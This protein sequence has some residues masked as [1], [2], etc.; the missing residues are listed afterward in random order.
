MK[1]LG[2]GFVIG[3]LVV[4]FWQADLRRG[5]QATVAQQRAELQLLRGELALGHELARVALHLGRTAHL[6]GLLC[7]KVYQDVL[8]A[9]AME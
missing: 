3:A 9:E 8:Y 6:H 1:Q 5:L 2:L 4:G 7:H